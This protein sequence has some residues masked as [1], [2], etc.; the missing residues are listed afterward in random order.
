[1]LLMKSNH[2]IDVNFET[3]IKV[4]AMKKAL[5]EK[6]GFESPVSEKLEFCNETLRNIENTENK[7][8]IKELEDQKKLDDH[9]IASLKAANAKFSN[10]MENLK[11]LNSQNIR[12]NIKIILKLHS[13]LQY[14]RTVKN[15]TQNELIECKLENK[16]LNLKV[17]EDKCELNSIE[18][19][20]DDG[21][22]QRQ[23]EPELV[24]LGKLLKEL[25]E[26]LAKIQKENL[27]GSNASEENFDFEGSGI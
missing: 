21:K 2:C 17:S 14:E 13:D 9:Q 24:V 26:V 7:Y 25:T 18:T 4:K 23:Q 20:K 22:N 3:R 12:E 8:H 19:Q 6:C 16:E 27:K 10:E 15:K 5:N 11:L 1:M